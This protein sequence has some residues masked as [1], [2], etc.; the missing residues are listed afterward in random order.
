AISLTV[1]SLPLSSAST[2]T[3]VVTVWVI[4]RPASVSRSR[5]RSPESSASTTATQVVA[6]SA[7]VR[8]APRVTPSTTGTAS[9]GKSGGSPSVRSSPSI[10][11]S[12][13]CSTTVPACSRTWLQPA[14][15]VSASS[16]A[17]VPTSTRVAQRRPLQRGRAQ[18]VSTV[19]MVPGYVTA[20]GA[21]GT[22][23]GAGHPESAPGTR[24]APGSPERAPAPRPGSG[25]PQGR[26]FDRRAG[27]HHHVQTGRCR[28]CGRCFVD[29]AQLQP[30]RPGA[31]LDRLVHH[32]AGAGGVHEHV[33]HVHRAGDLRQRA[34]PRGA[35]HGLGLRVH[36]DDLLA[37]VALQVP[38]HPVGGAGGVGRQPHHCPP[39]L[40][41][42]Q[43]S[44]HLRVVAVAH[45]VSLL[46]AAP[47]PP[48]SSGELDVEP[49]AAIVLAVRTS[50]G[51]ALQTG[52]RASVVVAFAQIV[53]RGLRLGGVTVPLVHVSVA[54]VDQRVEERT[55]KQEQQPEPAAVLGGGAAGQDRPAV[56]KDRDRHGHPRNR[57]IRAAKMP[58]ISTAADTSRS[59]GWLTGTDP[60]VSPVR[61]LTAT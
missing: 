39:A 35:V 15:V 27:V 41:G 5:A 53:H 14:T 28:P 7:A 44:D 29:H 6:P 40:G 8:T 57:N 43:A 37:Q 55:S 12:I 56:G 18:A 16:S 33:H 32:C 50:H 47:W 42:E 45:L 24:R 3:S 13:A 36:R 2:P 11:S 34:H 58:T 46:C 10:A 31:D 38:G 26:S 22:D 21:G 4:S 61:A 49:R 20:T 25:Q 9:A 30:H 60:I 54:Q 23:P 51:P 48:G 52:A 19:V 17:R 59:L 1:M